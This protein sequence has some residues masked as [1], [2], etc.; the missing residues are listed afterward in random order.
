MRNKVNCSR[1][2]S[3]TE[4]H[5]IIQPYSNDSEEGRLLVYCKDCTQDYAD[6]ITIISALSDMNP[7]QLLK[8]YSDGVSSSNP[9]TTSEIV[10][11]RVDR[12]F[13]SAASQMLRER[14]Q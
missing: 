6:R 2:A 4:L 5:V 9:E 8:L 1:C 13:V 7:K 10:F 3:N 12:E 14:K 11:G